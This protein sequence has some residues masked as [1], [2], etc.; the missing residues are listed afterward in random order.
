[1]KYYIGFIAA[2]PGN[3]DKLVEVYDEF[4]SFAAAVAYAYAEQRR[5]GQRGYTSAHDPLVSARDHNPTPEWMGPHRRGRAHRC[6][7]CAHLHR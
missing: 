3:E 1:M 5:W 7:E 2:M 6:K 4:P